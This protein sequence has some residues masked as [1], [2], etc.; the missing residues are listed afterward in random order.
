MTS[1]ATSLRETKPSTIAAVVGFAAILAASA[2]VTLP[3]PGTPVPFTLQ[4][5]VVVLAGLMLGPMAGAASMALYLA[6]GA[7]GLP[8]FSPVPG[9]PQGIARFMG[10][11]GG[12][13]IA[14]PVAAWVAGTI[15]GK[16]STFLRRFLAACAGIAMIFV[17]GI[18]QLTIQTGSIGRAL[19]LGITPFIA[20]DAVKA[21][22]AAAIT[23]PRKVSSRP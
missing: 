22:I 18:A 11:T 17:G 12:Y 8:V 2:Q 19:G 5:L 7:T 23:T 15:A 16:Q 3:I 21:L 4:P 20:L 1:I 14:Y 13:L 9:L 10:P 6:V